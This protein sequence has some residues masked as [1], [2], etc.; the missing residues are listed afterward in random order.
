[1]KKLLFLMFIFGSLVGFILPNTALAKAPTLTSNTLI[2]RLVLQSASDNKLW[3]VNPDNKERWYLHSDDDLK[4]LIEK[5][6]VK[7]TIKEFNQ[8]ARNTKSKTPANLIKKYGGH[9]IISPKNPEAAFF[10]NKANG[11]AYGIGNFN[12]FYNKLGKVIGTPAPDDILRA[13]PMNKEQETYDPTFYGIA[14]AKLDG[15]SILSANANSQRVLPLASL[16][17]LMTALVFISHNTDWDKEI[18]ITQEEID[19]PCTLQ[20]CGTTSEINLKVGDRIKIKDLWVGMLSASSNQSAVILADNSGLT[21]EEFISEMN[22]K[23][24]ELG[25]KKTKFVE[26]SGLSADN[27]STAEEFAK[28]AQ[29]A[30]A[31]LRIADATSNASYVFDVVQA[32]GSLRQINV[33]NRNYSL[34]AMGPR[35]SK[36]GYLVEAQRNAAVEKN[37]QI[38]VALHC[39]S[40]SQRNSIISNLMSTGPIALAN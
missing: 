7:P 4:L 12:H 27:I 3:Y 35:A 2:G 38:I 13:L 11:I 29:A 17:K 31:D 6:G 23:T 40:L 18:T 19:Y 22:S 15:L 28:I 21:R 32:D 37:G 16:T 24:K 36:S 10:L 30:F 34:M 33:L 39:Y 14:Y 20:L 1:M 26:M 9:I 5:V 8:L 25:L